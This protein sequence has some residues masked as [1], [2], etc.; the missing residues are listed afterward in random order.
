M[1]T[2]IKNKFKSYFNSNYF[3]T[4]I[5]IFF[6]LEAVWISISAA[7]PQAFDENFH[8]GL[9]KI[10]ARHLSP[11]LTKQPR[12]G[13]PYGDVA[14]HPSYLYHYLM[15]FPYRIYAYF[16]HNQTSQVIFLRL[17]DV[18]LFTVGLIYFYKFM[19]EIGLSKI[20]T[21]LS[22]LIFTLIP[23][24][25]QLAGQI[26]YDNM[27]FLMTGLTAYLT[28]KA[29]KQ[30]R[31]KQFNMK[32]IA[33]IVVLAIFASLVKFAYEPIAAGI[34]IYLIFVI[35]Q[36]SDK[37]FKNMW[38][39]LKNN[40]K[41]ISKLSKL[42]IIIFFVIATA[43]FFQRDGLNLIQYHTINPPCNDVLSVAQCSSYSVWFHNYVTHQELINNA[44]KPNKNLIIYLGQWV[45]WIW[46]RLFFAVSGVKTHFSNYPP[47]PLP[48]AAFL[49]L[50]VIVIF[51]LIKY[52]K[53]IFKTNDYINLMILVIT[54]YLI[55]LIF[56]GFQT[57]LYTNV[58]ELMNG[59]YL[60]PI[61]LFMAS[62]AG[63]F[64]TK[65]LRYHPRIKIFL[66]VIIVLMFLEGGG[67]L[68]F[69]SRSEDSWLIN[70]QTVKTINKT[71]KH[72]T[73]HVIIEGK[74]HYS[75][76]VWFF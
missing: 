38:L 59:R 2:N 33:S 50:A 11:F 25:P 43:L 68:T 27:M 10:Y 41:S 40:F 31:K 63:F 70:N 21:N 58:L 73:K 22:I 37:S 15:S 24:V 28:A 30:L 42:L 5:L 14:V 9:I 72:I 67:V 71:A 66:A 19:L 62:I 39:N 16:I 23:I 69:I 60:I 32:L 36:V 57:Y 53:K 8:F 7:Y 47:L 44:Y 46:Y 45:Y 55:A 17:I 48:S 20:Y 34:G 51:A 61:L 18:I 54:I 49:I 75:S 52:R 65:L 3:F 76:S 29:I 12:G 64:L 4:T 35:Y 26:N 13:N 1:W 74:K 6:I 56:E